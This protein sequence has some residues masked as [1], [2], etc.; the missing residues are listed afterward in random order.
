MGGCDIDVN[1]ILHPAINSIYNLNWPKLP[2]MIFWNFKQCCH[3]YL[4]FML[5]NKK[6]MNGLREDGV[7]SILMGPIHII[8]PYVLFCIFCREWQ[9]NESTLNIAF[10]IVSFNFSCKGV[11]IEVKR[12]ILILII[13]VYFYFYLAFLD[14]SLA[15]TA[16]AT[17]WLQQLLR[18]ASFHNM[19]FI[20]IQVH[21]SW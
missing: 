13:F 6:N 19:S 1:T 20:A 3:Q 18:C 7:E 9:I 5:T 16:S 11:P 17:R 2:K 14:V 4:I 8:S 12:K 21:N 15:F 10:V